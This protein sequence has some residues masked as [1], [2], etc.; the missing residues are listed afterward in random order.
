M[1]P[2]LPQMQKQDAKSFMMDQE[3]ARENLNEQLARILNKRKIKSQHGG[4]FSDSLTSSSTA[5]G[6]A[7]SKKGG[8]Y[9][10]ADLEYQKEQSTTI[11][12]PFSFSLTSLKK[13]LSERGPIMSEASS[14]SHF[15]YTHTDSALIDRIFDMTPE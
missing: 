7:S 10:S 14:P 6:E 12:N 4:L 8:Q 9:Q 3:K 2:F 15:Q 5:A 1:N 11:E 13:Y